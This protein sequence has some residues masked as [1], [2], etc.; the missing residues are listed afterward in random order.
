MSPDL[1]SYQR[2]VLVY[3]VQS[4]NIKYGTMGHCNVSNKMIPL[5]F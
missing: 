4:A 1:S 3:E 5:L 2:R